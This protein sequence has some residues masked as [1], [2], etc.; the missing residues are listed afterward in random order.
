MNVFIDQELEK[1][2]RR[3]LGGV[4]GGAVGGGGEGVY[5]QNLIFDAG[6]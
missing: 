5:R 1:G 4:V 2:D 3:W 6:S